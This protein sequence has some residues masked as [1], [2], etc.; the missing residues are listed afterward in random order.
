[1]KFRLVPVFVAVTATLLAAGCG[2]GSA[3]PSSSGSAAAIPLLREG[4]GSSFP[5]LNIAKT[6]QAS[7][8]DVMGLETLLKFGPQG[9]LEPDLATSWE[10]T[11]PVTYVYHLRHGVKFWDGHPLTA[12]DVAYSLNFERAADSQVAFAYSSVKNITASGPSTVVVTLAEPDASWQYTPAEYTSEVFEMKFAEDHKS[13]FGNAGVLVMGTGPWEIDS[14]DPTR[15][16]ELSANPHWWGG[17]VPIQRISFTFF[18]SPTSEA[19]AF[20]SGEIDLAPDVTDP[21]AFASTSGAKLVTTPSCA[22]AMFSMNTTIAPWSDVHVRRAVAYALNRSDIIAANGGYATPIYTYFPPQLLSS[23]ASQSQINS[24]LA[25]I[26]LYQYNLAKAKQEMAESAYP[27]GVSAT[28]TQVS[29]GAQLNVGEVIAAEL[30]KIGIKVQIKTLSVVAWQAMET[31][32]DGG[33]AS[34]FMTNGCFNPDPNGYADNLGTQNLA[35]GEWNDADYAPPAVNKLL[36]ASIATSNHAAR[37]AVYS[38]LF[39]TLASD[40]PY[41]G[42]FVSDAC[43]AL[44]SKFTYSDFSQ[45]FVYGPYALNVKQAA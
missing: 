6:I 7:Q 30:A 4:L 14:F 12:A 38:Q 40:E 43:I 42:L 8:I 34:S 2:A 44:S 21:Q 33:R 36:A 41:V 1:M 18:S 22:D 39:Q 20:R 19:L 16:A 32:P 28:I 45:W 27:H 9:Q 3:A 31:G 23:L 24:L 13:D 35:A 26:P 29:S 37:F 5:T 10:Q 11:S 25:S 15:G 17:K